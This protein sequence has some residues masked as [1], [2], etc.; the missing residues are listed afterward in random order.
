MNK[1]KKTIYFLLGIVVALLATLIINFSF[2]C[3]DREATAITSTQP[4][5]DIEIDAL[6]DSINLYDDSLCVLYNYLDSLDREL[7]Q[8]T[9]DSL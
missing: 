8:L 4:T 2:F 3:N 9:T 5:L 6:N 1:D 7:E